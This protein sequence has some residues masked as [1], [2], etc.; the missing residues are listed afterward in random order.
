MSSPRRE[1]EGGKGRGEGESLHSD[2]EFICHFQA[3]SHF[4]RLTRGEG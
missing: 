2:W 3:Q 1:T 4:K